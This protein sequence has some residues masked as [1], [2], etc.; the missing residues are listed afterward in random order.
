MKLKMKKLWDILWNKN[1]WL[2]KL[3]TLLRFI[4]PILRNYNL[5]DARLK[6]FLHDFQHFPFS[7]KTVLFVQ[8]QLLVTV[9]YRDLSDSNAAFMMM[10]Q[11]KASRGCKRGNWKKP[12]SPSY[13][14]SIS[15]RRWRR[16]CFRGKKRCWCC[17]SSAVDHPVD[18]QL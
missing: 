16:E 15:S 8:F 3:W 12:S 6:H 18:L 11:T 7:P 4:N 13:W 9:T 5:K 10:I 2:H 17:C 14:G 1:I